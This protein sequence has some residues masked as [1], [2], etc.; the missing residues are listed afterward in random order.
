MAV[1][2]LAIIDGLKSGE[3]QNAVARRLGC[4]VGTVNRVAKLNGLECHSVQKMPLPPEAARAAA[5]YCLERRLALLNKVFDK[6]EELIDVA[7]T[8]NKLQ[9]LCI[10]L[11]ILIDKRR[12]EDG[13]VT[14]RTEVNGGDARERIARRLDELAARRA[15]KA[16]AG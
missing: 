15:E 11:G 10:S 4:S 12:L 2:H 3:S 16:A 7:T 14:A 6:A 8:P 1:N 9:A 13:E 5:D